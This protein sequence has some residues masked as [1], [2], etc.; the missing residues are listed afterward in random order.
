MGGDWKRMG[1]ENE[2]KSIGEL[3]TLGRLEEFR[4]TDVP[5]AGKPSDSIGNLETLKPP[6]GL[7]DDG[8]AETVRRRKEGRRFRGAT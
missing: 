6:E 4:R 2:E 8:R 7:R 5:S 3:S 1:M